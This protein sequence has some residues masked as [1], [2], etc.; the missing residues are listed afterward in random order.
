MVGLDV[1][2]VFQFENTWL[3][4]SDFYDVMA[5]SYNMCQSSDVFTKLSFLG[6]NLLMWKELSCNFGGRIS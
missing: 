3:A 6:S 1:Q 2:S 5:S 4:E